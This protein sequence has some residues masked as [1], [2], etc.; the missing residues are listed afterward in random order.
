MF[1]SSGFSETPFSTGAPAVVQVSWLEIEAAGGVTH[2]TSGALVGAGATLSGAATRFRAFGTSGTLTGQGSTLSGAATRFRT[3]STSGALT[4]QGST[5]SGAATR[6]RAFGTSGALTGQGST[7]SGTANRFRAFGTSGTLVGQGATL[8]GSA[9]RS[10]SATVHD[11]SGALVGPGSVLS[12]TAGRSPSIELLGGGPGGPK[13][14]DSDKYREKGSAWERLLSPPLQERVRQLEPEVVEV[15]EAVVE[16]APPESIQPDR[17]EMQRALQQA[18]LAWRDAYL[19]IYTEL[20][21]EM[22]QQQEDEAI[23]LVVASLV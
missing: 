23:A 12:G 9:A 2:D 15:I 1:G 18:G 8:T 20:L 13:K 11:T 4:G 6:F 16:Q 10:G 3:F 14:R 22:R 5:L 21:A 17:D 7:L 19:E